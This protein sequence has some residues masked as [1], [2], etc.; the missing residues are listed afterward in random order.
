[1]ILK[2]NCYFIMIIANTSFS[3]T[4]I[5]EKMMKFKRLFFFVDFILSHM[6]LLLLVPNNV[7]SKY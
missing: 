7:P 1:M 4:I 6:V 2:V 3:Y 5:F